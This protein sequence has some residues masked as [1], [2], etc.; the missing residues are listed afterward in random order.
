MQNEEILLDP[1]EAHSKLRTQ[2]AGRKG[3]KDQ[4]KH[5]LEKIYAP[6]FSVQR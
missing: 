3:A 1:Q 2:T 6:T 4:P 5:S